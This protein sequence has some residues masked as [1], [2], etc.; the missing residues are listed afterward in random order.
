M[1]GSPKKA[2]RG[3]PRKAQRPSASPAP[4]TTLAATVTSSPAKGVLNRS[5]DL[6]SSSRRYTSEIA[7][8][9]DE[10]EIIPTTKQGPVKPRMTL[11]ES[12]FRTQLTE[13]HKSILMKSSTPNKNLARTTVETSDP[14]VKTRLQ[15]DTEKH[16]GVL[17]RSMVKQ[18]QEQIEEADSF[19]AEAPPEEDT[20]TTSVPS[21]E[22]ETYP[23]WPEVGWKEFALAAFVT[24]TAAVGYICYTTDL[25]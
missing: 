24:A 19:I 23:A 14:S 12:K 10:E 16:M 9:S 13:T 7:F 3:R 21:K 20:P 6:R 18:Q 22:N 17:T 4:V 8:S 25:C 2:R 11:S 5:Y 1:D 15:F